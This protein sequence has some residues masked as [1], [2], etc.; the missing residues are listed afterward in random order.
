[1]SAGADDWEQHWDQLAASAE[2]NPAQRYRRRLLCAILSAGSPRRIL[3]IG[4]GQGDLARDLHARF[5]TATIAGLELSASGC[6]ISRQKVPDA[7]FV[8]ANLLEPQSPGEL[9]GWADHATC[10]EVLEHVDEPQTLL[11]NARGYLAPGCRLVVTV[12]GGPMSAF[13]RHIGH[14]THY[15]V[16]TLRALLEGSGFIVDR[17]YAAGFPFH[18]L[19]RLVVIARGDKLAEDVSWAEGDRQPPLAR[20]VM[21]TFDG[22]FWMNVASS[23]WGWQIAASARLPA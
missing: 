5:P 7:T 2:R 21:G 1:M 9:A 11:A 23:P 19:Y 17:T 13:D 15:T 18:N 3:D 10:S 8:Q 4:S 16:H 6:A 14:R 20:L 22:L 12:P